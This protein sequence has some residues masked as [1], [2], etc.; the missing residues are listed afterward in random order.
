MKVK[1]VLIRRDK[2]KDY[3]NALRRSITECELYMHD[4]KMLNDLESL[5]LE[6]EEEFIEVDGSLKTFEE[7]DM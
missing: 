2:L 6:V 1:E 4:E 3:L 5:R 7:L